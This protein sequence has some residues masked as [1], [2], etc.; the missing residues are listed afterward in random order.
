M[1]PSYPWYAQSFFYHIYPLGFCGAPAHNDFSSAPVPRLQKVS[2]WLP[3]IQSLGANALYLG[4]LFEASAHGYDTANYYEVDRRLGERSTLKQLSAEVHRR[5]MRLVLDGVFNHV[6]RDFW[7]FRDVQQH[8]QHS[9]Y[10]DWFSGL[11]FTQRSPYGDPFTYQ[12]WNGY[13]DLVRLNQANPAVRE[14]L[15]NAVRLWVEEFDIDGLRL[16][17][18]DCLDADFMQALRRHCDTLKPD[19]WL[20]GEVV[21]GDYRRWANPHTLHAVTNYECYKSLYSSL[22]DVNYFEMAWSLNRQFGPQG[23]Y[24]GLPLYNFADNHDVERIASQLKDP[25]QLS[26]LYLLLFSM[27]GVPSLYYGSEWGLAGKK[28]AHSDAA[29][30]PCLDLPALQAASPHPYLPETLRRLAQLRQGSAALQFG[31]YQ[32]LQVAHEQLAFLRTN[33]EES[34]IVLLNASGSPARF[35]L[36]LPPGVHRASDLLNPGQPCSVANGRLLVEE[37]PARW[38]C[39]IA[40]S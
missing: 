22:N 21:H 38:G 7:A 32:Q 34:V 6:G 12:P 24:A 16:D 15:F 28:S 33:G 5:G 4:P 29:L 27:P 8:G 31:D 14:H 23:M 10:R 25:Q 26:L 17:A 20:M 37:V 13:Y 11:D 35:D 18:A 1:N 40:V 3:H 9:A 36:P 2:A 39:L 19:F 30:R